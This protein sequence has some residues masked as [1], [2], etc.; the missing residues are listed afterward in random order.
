MG[1][2]MHHIVSH[3]KIIDNDH[4]V[5]ILLKGKGKQNDETCHTFHIKLIWETISTKD[6]TYTIFRQL[7]EVNNSDFLF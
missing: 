5:F 4:N 7:F 1:T 6:V 2:H 3:Q